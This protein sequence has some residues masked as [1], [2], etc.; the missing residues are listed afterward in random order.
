MT[1]SSSPKCS[2]LF[3]QLCRIPSPSLREAAVGD[4]VKA[5]LDRLGIAWRED[6]AASAVGGDCG[7][8]ICRVNGKRDAPPVIVCAHLDTVPPGDLIEPV[9]RDGRWENSAD[10]ILGAD[11]KAAV[12]SV[13]AAL[14]EW[15]ED[16]PEVDV[17][18]IFTVAEEIS[19][20]GA[21]ELDFA[22]LDAQAAFFFDHPTPIG[23][24]IDSSPSHH[25]IELEFTGQ[26]AHA[27]VAPEEGASAIKAAS[28]AVSLYPSGRID[29]GTTSNIGLIAGGT[30]INVVPEHCRVIAE[31]R[32]SDPASLTR[33]TQTLIEAAHEAAGQ[34][35]CS[36]DVVVRPSFKGY[37]H[38]H[39][40][41]AVR[42]A[43]AAL[44]TLGIGTTRIA[45]AGGS[46]ANVFEDHGIPSVNL[47][48]GSSGTHTSEEAIADDDLVRL[49]EVIKHIPASALAL[50]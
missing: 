29:E 17:I 19:L 1:A 39:G 21:K 16:P 44:T 11:N 31:V 22:L 26:A 6:A 38:A 25:T 34:H 50:D 32:S 40:H 9:C 24:V 3:E 2:Q 28:T 5:E 30:A 23:T 18:A 14:S 10:G 35:G 12:A 13:L 20:L 8:L 36:A 4:F 37:H 43:E 47:G 7:N 49:V 48:D 15:A 46:D 42:I 33:E 45:S 27:G 41:R